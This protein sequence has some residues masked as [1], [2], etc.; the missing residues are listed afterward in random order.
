M[1]FATGLIAVL[2]AVALG[3]FAGAVLGAGPAEDSFLTA[4]V[5]EDGLGAVVVGGLAAGALTG[6]LLPLLLAATLRGAADKPRVP[7]REAAVKLLAVLGSGAYLLTIGLAA[8]QLGR[9]LPQDL[10]TTLSVFAVG[11]GWM[12]LAL[13][14]RGR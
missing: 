8:A 14:P 11:L 7:P 4:A 12:P 13:V 6:L 10:T 2:A 5:P 9:L 3:G 1:G